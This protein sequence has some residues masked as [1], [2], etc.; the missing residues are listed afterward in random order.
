[1]PEEELS[2]KDAPVN[3]SPYDSRLASLLHSSEEGSTGESTAEPVSSVTKVLDA[4][5]K[6]NKRLTEI[7]D[8]VA[9]LDWASIR[10]ATLG[11]SGGARKSWA[12]S[13]GVGKAE[14]G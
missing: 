12:L 13:W 3:Y 9:C 8:T 10:G 4:I 7:R 5:D 11:I 2:D 14:E 6:Q 1:M